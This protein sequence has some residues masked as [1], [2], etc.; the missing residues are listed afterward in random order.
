MHV[1][2]VLHLSEMHVNSSE[3]LFPEKEPKK[4]GPLR[5]GCNLQV[6]PTQGV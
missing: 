5:A 1:L 2:I 4:A 3:T 6:K